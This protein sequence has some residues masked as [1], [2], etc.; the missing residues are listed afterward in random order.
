M[1]HIFWK[2][3]IRLLI[4]IKR[5]L[6]FCKYKIVRHK[7]TYAR[8]GQQVTSI[9]DLPELS[10]VETMRGRGNMYAPPP[11]GG[12][13][14]GYARSNDQS[15][16]KAYNLQQQSHHN[17]QHILQHNPHIGE[18]LT[19]EQAKKYHGVI[20]RKHVPS[21]E[22]G[23]EPYHG[24]PNEGYHHEMQGEQMEAPQQSNP[25][26]TDISCLDIA[27]HVSDC[28]ICSKF[29]N[30]DKTVYII[31]IVVLAIVCLLLLKKV[32]DV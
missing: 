2:F 8:Q 3:I 7:M 25:A 20:R 31:V 1:I 30:N 26:L 12:H 4:K 14:G 5:I 19:Q 17:V 21:P 27:N 18:N 23:M 24:Y 13:G 22:A 32:L 11:S 10:D 29:Y 9:D 15:F 6:D 28:P 16:A